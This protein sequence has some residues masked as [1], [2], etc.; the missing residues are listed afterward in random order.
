[1]LE[2]VLVIFRCKDI[3]EESQ[4]TTKHKLPWIVFNTDTMKTADSLEELNQGTEQVSRE[5]A[6]NV[7]DGVLYANIST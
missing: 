1:M 3:S 5:N 7:K 4:P 2:G 6:H